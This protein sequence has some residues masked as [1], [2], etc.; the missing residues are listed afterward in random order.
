MSVH[1]REEE[2]SV[3]HQSVDT[4]SWIPVARVAVRTNT[5]RPHI[6]YLSAACLLGM[7][8]SWKQYVF[9]VAL[10]YSAPPI[11]DRCQFWDW[12]PW[13]PTSPVH[14]VQ[15]IMS[16]LFEKIKSAIPSGGLQIA[17]YKVLRQCQVIQ[18]SMDI[19]YYF[20]SYWIVIKRYLID[21]TY[22]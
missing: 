10:L 21:L 8:R 5:R 13:T 18:N 15:R 2:E 12:H 7:G 20:L 22:G 16:S 1:P 11:V 3:A 19:Y 4:A 14:F 17:P 6:N 9:H